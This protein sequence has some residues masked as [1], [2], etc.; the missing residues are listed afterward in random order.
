MLERCL[1]CAEANR[2]TKIFCIPELPSSPVQ[3]FHLIR[4]PLYALGLYLTTL[5]GDLAKFSIVR[6]LY[7][8]TSGIVQP[9][10]NT[11]IK[12]YI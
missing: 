9:S 4:K 12:R 5:C 8:T 3:I 7:H 2:I 10:H 6:E 1:G 11:I